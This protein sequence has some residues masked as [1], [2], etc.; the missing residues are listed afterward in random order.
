MPV[1]RA[2]ATTYTQA[3]RGRRGA[4]AEPEP[5]PEPQVGVAPPQP[6]P[7]AEEV[8]LF[9][10]DFRKFGRTER[11][12]WH[13]C[14]QHSRVSDTPVRF[15]GVRSLKHACLHAALK[16]NVTIQSLLAA[17]GAH[18][19]ISTPPTARGGGASGLPR[20]IEGRFEAPR[21]IRVVGKAAD[22]E[23]QQ[24]QQQPQQQQPQQQPQAQ[25]PAPP[26]YQPQPAPPGY[27][28]QPAPAGYQQPPAP[29]GHMQ[30]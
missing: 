8:W 29:P 1:G 9:A 30:P 6:V 14:H 13:L 20:W 2:N 12:L 4:T 17:Q 25:P 24:P 11:H 28:P 7:L 15:P 19:R 10:P 23:Q 5:E 16:Q 27:Q 3:A 21:V 22:R 18:S 26:G